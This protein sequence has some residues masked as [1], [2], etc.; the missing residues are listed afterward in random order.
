MAM[1][2]LR[3]L[4]QELILD[5]NKRPRNF[6]KPEGANRT[7]LGNN[8]LCGDKLN[9]YLKIKDNVIEDI[10]FE[11]SGCAISTASASVMTEML[12]GKTFEEAEALF[13]RF[14]HLMT[15]EEGEVDLDELGKMAVFA[16]VREFPVRVKCATL[17][18]HTAHAAIGG[19]DEPVTTE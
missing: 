17:A 8:P 19:R 13:E 10:G 15:D 16:G 7:A 4:Y 1:S 5:H 18:W 3:E 11:G 9:V 12:K 6:K 14:H 2:D